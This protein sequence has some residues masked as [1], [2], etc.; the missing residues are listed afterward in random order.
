MKIKFNNNYPKLHN[1]KHARLL[2]CLSD[3]P[4]KLLRTKYRELLFYDT[5]MSDGR[6]YQ[7]WT[8]GQKYLMLLFLGDKGILFTTFRTDNEENRDKYAGAI[9]EVFEIIIE[10]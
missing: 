8:V 6:F 7:S 9:G 2:M 5:Q 10:G 3:I 1:Q 4:E